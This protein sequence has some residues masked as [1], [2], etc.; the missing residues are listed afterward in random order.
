MEA[1]VY[2]VQKKTFF[3]LCYILWALSQEVNCICIKILY[4]V[5]LYVPYLTLE[6]ITNQTFP[7]INISQNISLT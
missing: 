6:T 3:T 5:S 1:S 2:R 4:R 7:R